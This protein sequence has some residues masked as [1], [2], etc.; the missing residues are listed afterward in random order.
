MGLSNNYNPMDL[1]GKTVLVTGASSGIGKQ[2][3]ITISRLGAKVICIA[4]NEEMLKDTISALAGD[5]HLYYSLD[6][7]D[8]A[9]IEPFIKDVSPTWGGQS[10]ALFIVQEIPLHAR[11]S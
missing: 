10:T 7:S 11:Y 9:G 5:G 1:T 6:L 3:A 4:R 8:L 2:T